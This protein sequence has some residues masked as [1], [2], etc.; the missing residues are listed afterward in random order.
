[1]LKKVV[2]VAL[3]SLSL[4]AMG[5]LGGG[6]SPT[7]NVVAPDELDASASPLATTVGFKFPSPDANSLVALGGASKAKAT[8]SAPAS[9]GSASSTPT[10]TPAATPKPTP[11]PT[12]TPTPT[13]TPAPAVQRLSPLDSNAPP[14]AYYV[15]CK[16][17]DSVCYAF[18]GELKASASAAYYVPSNADHARN[19][20]YFFFTIGDLTSVRS[21]LGRYSMQQP[22]NFFAVYHYSTNSG[23]DFDSV[24]R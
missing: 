20:N 18:V 4:L 21:I 5:C 2:F 17:V 10:A 1:M 22:E 19:A 23:V 3:L 16:N 13:P 7:G 24:N 14:N 15:T 6:S 9:D 11:K 8:V 12:A